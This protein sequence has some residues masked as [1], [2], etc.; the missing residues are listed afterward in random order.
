MTMRVEKLA[1]YTALG[2]RVHAVKTEEAIAEMQAQIAEGGQGS[3][4]AVTGMHGLSESRKDSRFREILNRAFL[5]VPDG[6]P[7]V[8]LARIHRIPLRRRVCG[9][10][11]MESFCRTTGPKFRHF[12]YGGA[13]GVAQDLGMKL[14]ARFGIIV[15]GT[16][17]PPFRP[18]T[19]DE[20]S[21]VQKRVNETAPHVLWVG[22]STPKQEKWMAEFGSQLRVPLMVGVGAAFDMNSGRLSRAPHWMQVWGLEWFYR[23]LQEPGRLWKRYLIIIPEAA[24]DVSLELL[25]LRK[26]E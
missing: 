3:Y 4:V 17:T 20:V 12:F 16:Y 23:L 18:L 7:L 1:V 5:V 21:E 25:G 9:S 26:F 10:E 22:L 14:A 6:M 11:L 24:W 2:V 19:L 15:A 13:P 8:W